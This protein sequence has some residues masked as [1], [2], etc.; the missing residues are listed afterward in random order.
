MVSSY[1]AYVGFLQ[2]EVAHT[3]PVLVTFCHFLQET[4]KTDQAASQKYTTN[5]L[6]SI[7]NA[8][9][10]SGY[11][12]PETTNGR[13]YSPGEPSS[14]QLSRRVRNKWLVALTLTRNPNLVVERKAALKQTRTVSSISDDIVKRVTF[15]VTSA[16]AVIFTA[17]YTLD[18]QLRY[19]EHTV[20]LWKGDRSF[21]PEGKLL[22]SETLVASLRYSGYHVAFTLWGFIIVQLLLWLVWSFII[23]FWDEAR[24]LLEKYWLTLGVTFAFYYG[25][26]YISQIVFLQRAPDL[27]KKS[28]FICWK[29]TSFGLDNRRVFHVTVYILMF[30]NFLL[31]IVS[32]F[33]RIL[34]ALAFG[35]LYIG[36]LDR[37]LLMRDWET[38][39]RG[40]TAYV[41][42]L[43][44]EV[45]HT[46]PVL[47]TFCHFLQKTVKTDQASSQ[48]YTTKELVSIVN[49]QLESGYEMP[50][51]TNGRCYSPREPS[52]GQLSRRMRNKWLV[53]LTLTRN[54]SLVSERKGAPKEA[55]RKR[56]E[57]TGSQ[58]VSGRDELFSGKTEA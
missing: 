39:D 40:Y 41:G 38:W 50:E 30:V 6:V 20:K 57:S 44:L 34:K 53:A 5:D 49:S 27:E 8:Q 16:V 45:A 3:H 35:T 37:L 32:C 9:I 58:D 25:Q 7:V 28:A 15:W 13:C 48:K 36:R 22:F 19:R 55:K 46:H 33:V 56:A 18:M 14:G 11:D 54:P 24:Y 4:V 17:V 31:G 21:V 43:Q 23:V 10:E 1:T 52:T 29:R 51:T 26:V 12:V 2:L 47:I 42:F